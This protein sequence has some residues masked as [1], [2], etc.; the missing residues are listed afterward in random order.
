MT[1]LATIDVDD[2][3]EGIL[4]ARISGDLDLSNLA[5]V[6]GALL[7]AM[8]NQAEALVADLAGVT[9]IDSSGVEML[10]RLQ[11]SLS[12]RQQRLAVA[13]PAEA[14]TRRA[15]ELSGAGGEVA[16]YATV[17]EAIVALTAPGRGQEP[18]A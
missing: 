17:A 16:L 7:D 3:G 15:L 2:Q 5:A 9:F 6:Q 8:S 11:Q 4:I 10:F 18:A 14:P 13:I 12:V 1:D